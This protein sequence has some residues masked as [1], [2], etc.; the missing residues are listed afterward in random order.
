M[1][2]VKI[3]NGAIIGGGSV[4]THSVEDYEIVAGCP[5][6]H[7]NWRFD[8]E[9]RKQLLESEWWNLPDNVIKDNMSLFSPFNDITKDTK[10]INQLNKIKQ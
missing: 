6:K 5:A 4:V 1:P 7:I 9:T 8:E 10:I 2:G 3:G